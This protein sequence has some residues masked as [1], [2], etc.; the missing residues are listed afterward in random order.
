M[1]TL[2]VRKSD[3]C[4][5]RPSRSFVDLSKL[6]PHLPWS[7]RKQFVFTKGAVERLV[8]A[9]ETI[10][11]AE[12]PKPIDEKVQ[13]EIFAN[14]EALAEQGL[15]VL[16]L[17]S[18]RYSGA[19][20]SNGDYDRVDLEKG[21]TLYGLVGLYDPPRPETK[22]AVRQCHGAGV[23]VHMLTGDHAAT[24]RAIALQVGI[25][26]RQVNT[27]SKEAVDAMVMTAAQF[28][29]L[30]DEQVDE[31]PMLPLVIA[32]CA[33]HTKVR[34]VE[35]LHRRKAFVA[36]T[37]DGGAS[38]SLLFVSLT[39]LI[40][41]ADTRRPL[42]SAVNDSPSL[43]RSDVGI[44][45]G[46]NGSDVA[47]DASDI[48]LADDNFASILAAVEEGRRMCVALSRSLPLALVR[49]VTRFLADALA[50]LP[51]RF[52]NIQ[53]F[54]LHLLA[55]NVMQALVLLIGL[56]FKDDDNLSVFPL[57][58]VE[59]LWVIMITS[60]FPAMGLGAEKADPDIL[61]RKPHN[62]KMG[63]FAPEVLLDILVYGLIGAAVDI[64]TFAVI[65]FG[66]GDG[67]LG[68]N[69]NNEIDGDP[70]SRLVFRARSATFSTMVFCLL[71]LAFE[72]M[73]LR[74]SFFHMG[75]PGTEKRCVTVV[76][77]RPRPRTGLTLLSSRRPYTQW[78][79]DVWGNQFLFWSVVA[80]FLITFPCVHL[81][82]DALGLP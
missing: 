5:S 19:S 35:A 44:A 27:M 47:K 58:P 79:H 66:F 59:I 74:R 21:M 40:Q 33:P 46:Q 41:G 31:L 48:V 72:M 54:V 22:G 13:E 39:L 51:C 45:M 61:T 16:G 7:R 4:V 75:R 56:A 18:K 49:S 63:V 57:A 68:R 3:E 28:D 82:L 70:G 42:R 15:R 14:V 37:G 80:G 12:G 69:S 53:K 67:N 73:D 43:K 32:R 17:A 76:L 1:S 29:R 20:T 23:Q 24:A 36:M 9:C 60:S 52:T 26:P 55:G 78:A 38:L 81:L 6:I 62:L 50:P 64:G 11:T 77:R 34:M 8:E 2:Y 30:S 65:V 25:L 10:E 71:W